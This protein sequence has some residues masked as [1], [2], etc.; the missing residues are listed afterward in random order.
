MLLCVC[1]P[2]YAKIVNITSAHAYLEDT[3]Y[4]LDTSFDFSLS[5]ESEKA[6]RHGIPIEIH[7]H[8]QLRLKRKWLWDRTISEKK[9]VYRL[10]HKPLT[11]NFLTINLSTGLRKSYNNLNSALDEINSISKM[12]LFEQNILSKEESYA[13][14]I[15]I[16]LDIASLPPPMRPQAYFSSS[17]K[18]S[19]K[20]YEWEVIR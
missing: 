11:K 20:W 18:I 12:K 19:S 17:W 6:L 15:K 14:R 16:Y 7:T 3:T 9:I 1:H 8:F 2:A 5:E 13:S 10:E 4:Y